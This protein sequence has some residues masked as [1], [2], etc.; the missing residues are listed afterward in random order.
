MLTNGKKSGS[1][2]I[3]NGDKGF[4]YFFSNII[5]TQKDYSSSVEMQEF[6]ST[7]KLQVNTEEIIILRL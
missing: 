5:S 1:S 4:S 7:W 3:E 6:P 2:H